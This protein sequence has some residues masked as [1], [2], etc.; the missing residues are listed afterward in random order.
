MFSTWLNDWQSAGC[1]ACREKRKTFF[2]RKKEMK[3]SKKASTSNERSDVG[4]KTSGS[5]LSFLP[6]SAG[7]FRSVKNKKLFE[8]SEFFLFSVEKCR[9]RQKSAAG[10]FSFC[11][12]FF[13]A[14]KRKKKSLCGLSNSEAPKPC[15]DWGQTQLRA[16]II[17]IR[18]NKALSWKSW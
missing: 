9:S 4:W 15:G 12:F 7:A 1:R 18:C 13:C 6:L 2:W 3:R 5:G 10:A 8:R 16:H 11:F 17:I 14:D